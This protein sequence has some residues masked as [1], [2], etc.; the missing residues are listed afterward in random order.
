MTF[1][2]VIDIDVVFDGDFLNEKL[3]P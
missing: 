1:T 3:R 2:V